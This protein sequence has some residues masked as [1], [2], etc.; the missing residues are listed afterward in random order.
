VPRPVSGRRRFLGNLGAH[1][2]TLALV[3]LP[4]AALERAEPRALTLPRTLPHTLPR[5]GGAPPDESYWS[6]VRAQFPIRPGLV[7]LNAANLC[8]APRSVIE[9]VQRAGADVD[10]DV[11]FQNRAKYDEMRERTREGLARY[12]GA[13]PEEIAIVRN[14]TEANN[15]IVGG[16]TLGRGDEVVVFDLNH[17]TNNV[18]WDVGAARYGYTV[19]RVK[20]PADP[21][22]PAQLGELLVT[23]VTRRTRVLALTDVSNTTGIRLP[24]AAICGALKGR[25]L[26]IH[27]DGA[28]TF[29]AMRVNLREIGCDSYSG[30]AHKWFLGPKEAGVLYV[31]AERVAAIWP[32][33]V[34]HV[35]GPRVEPEPKGARKFETLG[36]RNDATLAAIDAAL[37]LHAAIGPAAVEAR[38]AQLAERLKEGLARLPG[39]TLVTPR[40]PELSHGVVVTRF[41]N[42]DSAAMYQTLYQQHGIAGAPVGG[43][44]FCPH[45]HNTMEEIERTLTAVER[46]AGLS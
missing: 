23:A 37:E 13:A 12:L 14:T 31:K 11:S 34:G 39:A 3:P 4:L 36:Q 28:Q 27:V 30:S 15:T 25:R 44:R 6:L 29:G 1:A 43:L 18:A 26:H 33:V 2:A 19:R 41:A 35:W 46:L 5:S 10:A 8:P 20:A 24:I 45:V 17:P 16:L 22:T 40:S 21:R 42:H 32:N 38:I 7:P 9:A